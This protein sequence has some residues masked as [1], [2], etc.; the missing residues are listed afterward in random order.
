MNQR[1]GQFFRITVTNYSVTNY[2][3]GTYVASK[4]IIFTDENWQWNP[5]SPTLSQIQNIK[6]V[7][8]KHFNKGR[9]IFVKKGPR[10]IC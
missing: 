3:F 6:T 2:W 4:M 9:E 8:L 10:D 5:D 1:W 7:F